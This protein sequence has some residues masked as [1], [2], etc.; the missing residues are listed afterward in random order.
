VATAA[1]WACAASWHAAA[2]RK[3]GR[4]GSRARDGRLA[5]MQQC[6]EGGRE[7]AGRVAVAW[8][9]AKLAGCASTLA[10]GGLDANRD[11]GVN[12]FTI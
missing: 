8:V 2:Y 10:A 7:A 9:Y 3:G 6:K 12:V 1:V 5:N 4:G 11:L